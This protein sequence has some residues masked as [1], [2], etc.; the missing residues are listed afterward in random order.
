MDVETT[1]DLREWVKVVEDVGKSCSHHGQHSNIVHQIISFALPSSDNASIV[2]SKDDVIEITG[3]LTSI[4]S[5]NS[6][7]SFQVHELFI[8]RLPSLNML[9]NAFYFY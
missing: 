4:S 1:A 2:K 6:V 8:S 5:I 7:L 3:K 9:L